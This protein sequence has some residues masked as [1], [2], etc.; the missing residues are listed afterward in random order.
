[1]IKKIFFILLSSFVTVVF[2][3]FFMFL[4][5]NSVEMRCQRQPDKSFTCVIDKRLFDQVV[6]STRTVK[7]VLA[8]ET[9]KDCD[10]DGCSYRTE[11]QLTDGGAEPFD[12]VYTDHAPVAAITERV[13]KAIRQ[14]D[15]PGF[16]IK[17]DLQWW[18]V[19]M[20]GAM[21]IIGLGVEAFLVLK[22][23]YD[24]IIKRRRDEFLQ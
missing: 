1:M 6:T 20:L 21:S 18:L 3:G 10:S 14:N 13:N 5:A 8:A 15:G 11:L 16:T 22:S 7:G 9:V 24:G 4:F 2:F 19:I 17:A 12:E 23:L